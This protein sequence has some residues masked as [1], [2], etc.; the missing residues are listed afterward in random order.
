M[1]S[2]KTGISAQSSLRDR[3]ASKHRTD[4]DSDT[5]DSFG[6][7]LSDRAWEVIREFAEFGGSCSSGATCR[8]CSLIALNPCTSIPEWTRTVVSSMP[9]PEIEIYDRIPATSL[10]YSRFIPETERTF[11]FWRTS[12]ARDSASRAGFDAA[13]KVFRL[14]PDGARR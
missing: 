13:G 12:A 11:S 5:C 8:R 3:P 14:N 6:E 9:E 4:A 2:W 10:D 7:G 1:S